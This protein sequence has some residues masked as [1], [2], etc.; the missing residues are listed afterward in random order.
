MVPWVWAGDETLEESQFEQALAMIEILKP[1]RAFFTHL[2]H[3]LKHVDIEKTL[4]PHVKPSFDGLR[5]EI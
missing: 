5:L 2:A 4:P 3:D 1:K